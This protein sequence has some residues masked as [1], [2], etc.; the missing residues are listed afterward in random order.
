MLKQIPVYSKSKHLAHQAENQLGHAVYAS[1]QQ[2]VSYFSD[3]AFSD[4]FKRQCPKQGEY[5][6]FEHSTYLISA[7]FSVYQ[8]NF[9]PVV[10]EILNCFP[11]G[12]LCFSCLECSLLSS[13][14]LLLHFS[15][16]GPG[17]FFGLEV[18]A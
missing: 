17:F 15:C 1:G 4:F 3:V 11:C 10:K 7:I 2:C 9:G 6:L 5:V 14:A 8:I 16:C 12:L 13:K 18:F